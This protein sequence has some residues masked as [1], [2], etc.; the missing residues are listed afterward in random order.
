[1]T[2]KK[3]T[4]ISQQSV[5]QP[6]PHFHVLMG[7][8]QYL[9]V[10]H[11]HV[12]RPPTDVMEEGDRLVILVEIAGMRRGEFHV[13]LNSQRLMISGNRPRPLESPTAYHQLEVRYGEFR[14]EVTLPWPVDD[15]GIVAEYDD[16]FLRIELPR[17]SVEDVRL[18]AVKKEDE[19]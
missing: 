5:E 6:S 8:Q 7:S 13:A 12:L 19:P 18:I 17:A 4:I 11:A 14:T 9:V 15:E 1:M 10:K 2:G 3:D 16:G